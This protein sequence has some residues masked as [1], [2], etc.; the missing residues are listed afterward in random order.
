MAKNASFSISGAF[1]MVVF[2]E[3]NKKP[4]LTRYVVCQLT[5]NFPVVA[6]G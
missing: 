4:M 1:H 6:A 5:E 2:T 3:T